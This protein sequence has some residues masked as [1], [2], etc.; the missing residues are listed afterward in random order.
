[1]RIFVEKLCCVFCF[2]SLLPIQEK[3]FFAQ[4][5]DYVRE[6]IMGKPNGCDAIIIWLKSHSLEKV[7]SKFF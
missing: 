5:F 6:K 4:T 1:V 3:I 7:D 2:L